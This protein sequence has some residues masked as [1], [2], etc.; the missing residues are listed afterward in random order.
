MRVVLH[1]GMPKTGSSAIQEALTLNRE[2][3]SDKGILYP[4]NPKP[5]SKQNQH[6][7]YLPMFC[8]GDRENWKNFPSGEKRISEMLGANFD[9]YEHWISDLKRQITETK[10]HTLVLSE[11]RFFQ[12]LAK[13]ASN[14]HSNFN[15]FLSKLNVSTT[16]FEMIGYLRNPADYYLSMCQQH[17]KLYPYLKGIASANYI[18][19]LINISK[20]YRPNLRVFEFNRKNFPAGDVVRHFT[21]TAFN[22]ELTSQG[23]TNETVSGAA[24]RVLQDYWAL[25][26]PE[27]SRRVSSQ[28]SRSL[29]S[30]IRVA[31]EKHGRQRPVMKEA[32]RSI[33]F[34]SL[35]QELN[36]L[37]QNYQI[38]F[39]ELAHKE[40]SKTSGSTMRF[41]PKLVSE[42]IE[43]DHKSSYTILLDVLRQKMT[44]H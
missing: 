43:I 39:G 40:K 34:E 36:W 7:I 8:Y 16:N 19:K 17:L 44:D 42:I 26:L 20:L 33:I 18:G 3:L 15:A 4:V 13:S 35:A 1:I 12:A 24:M 37:R 23:V 9:Y 2:H 41:R 10:P 28:Q 6:W 32:V 14:I 30:A 27:N 21:K 22:F 25:T 38:D 11:E 29:I 31:E 5:F